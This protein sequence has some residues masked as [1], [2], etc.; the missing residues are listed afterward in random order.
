MEYRQ[1]DVGGE[2]VFI[3]DQIGSSGT[4]SLG[5]IAPGEQEVCADNSDYL[6]DEGTAVTII[7]TDVHSP[8]TANDAL[9]LSCFDSNA[10]DGALE[11]TL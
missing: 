7:Q 9:P 11:L 2:K 5:A 4:V 3:R 6:T 8:N 1:T 10:K